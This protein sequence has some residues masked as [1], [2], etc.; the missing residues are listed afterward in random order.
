[1][2]S[3]PAAQLPFVRST[4]DGGVLRLTLNRPAQRNPL[5]VAMIA[6]LSDALAMAA[7]DPQVH[8]VVIAAE[9]PAFCAGHDLRELTAARD[10]ADRGAGFFQK[11]MSG[12]SALM[13]AIAVH[14]KPVIAE[15]QGIATAAGCQLVA[16]CDLAFAADTARFAT[17]GVNIGLF[18][19]TPSVPLVRTIGPKAAMQMLLTGDEIPAV[20]ALEIGLINEVVPAAELNAYVQDLARRIASKPSAIVQ[21]GKAA[22]GRHASMA[23]Q[24]AYEFATQVMTSNLQRDEAIAGIGQFLDR[25]R[26]KL[27]IDKLSE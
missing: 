17:P 8:V 3:E 18:C 21:L 23:L 7:V 16:A 15:V 24:E 6:A 5:S 19:T 26:P 4:G 12:C 27:E 11:T 14:P 2:S 13:E 20:K 25:K 22:V 1:M 10:A 9:G